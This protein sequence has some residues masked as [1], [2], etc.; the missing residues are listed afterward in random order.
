LSSSRAGCG[1]LSVDRHQWSMRDLPISPTFC[2]LKPRPK[3]TRPNPGTSSPGNLD[4]S[5]VRALRVQP[6]SSDASGS[7]RTAFEID[8]TQGAHIRHAHLP[9]QQN[10]LAPGLR[11][12]P[13]VAQRRESRHPLRRRPVI[14]FPD[15]IGVAGIDVRRSAGSLVLSCTRYSWPPW[16]SLCRCLLCRRLSIERYDRKTAISD[17]ASRK[18]W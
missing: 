11:P 5:R 9:S 8:Q 17:C 13:S 10:V 6:G 12:G 2:P 16:Q 14:M 18:N 1:T 7:R 3:P 15:V 4:D